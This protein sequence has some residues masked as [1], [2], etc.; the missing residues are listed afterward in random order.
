MTYQSTDS[1]YAWILSLPEETRRKLMKPDIVNPDISISEYIR[2]L[3]ER[4]D[5]FK[6]MNML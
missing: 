6:K 5:M 3:K 2:L 4:Y 1:D